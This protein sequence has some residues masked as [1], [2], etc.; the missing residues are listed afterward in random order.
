MRVTF[1]DSPPGANI[2]DLGRWPP[3]LPPP[4]WV[5]SV[6]KNSYPWINGTWYRDPSI[7]W[8]WSTNCDKWHGLSHYYIPTVNGKPKIE[9]MFTET[10][11][12]GIIRPLIY[13][14]GT[15]GEVFMFS[16]GGRYYFWRDCEL[17]VHRLNFAG[18]KE[19]LEHAMQNRPDQFP[20][21]PVEPRGASVSWSWP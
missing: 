21:V 19:F 9:K 10:F 16:A 1:I 6:R 5:G 20:D 11:D 17:F 15:Y 18:P 3:G 14:E 2:E 8:P 4:G 13:A 12:V 7:P